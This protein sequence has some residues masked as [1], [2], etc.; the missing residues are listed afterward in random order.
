M[1]TVALITRRNKFDGKTAGKEEE[2]RTCERRPLL[3]ITPN[4]IP[5]KHLLQ[6]ITSL[7]DVT[8]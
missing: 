6:H 8:D 4:L 2:G 1:F 7:A 3:W 5:D